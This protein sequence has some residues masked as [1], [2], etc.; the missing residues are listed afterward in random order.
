MPPLY[1]R[2]ADG[3]GGPYTIR[4]IEYADSPLSE[5]VTPEHPEGI[6]EVWEILHPDDPDY[7][8]GVL[9]KR[10]SPRTGKVLW[11]GWDGMDETEDERLGYAIWEIAFHSQQY[12]RSSTGWRKDRYPNPPPEF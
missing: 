8:C 1:A 2:D 3:T 6:L 7:C 11:C 10:R 5:T 12:G 4:R 9:L